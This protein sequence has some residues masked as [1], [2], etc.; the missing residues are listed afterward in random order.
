MQQI[1]I[2]PRIP[3]TTW[4]G[5]NGPCPPVPLPMLPALTILHQ[6]HKCSMCLPSATQTWFAGKFPLWLSR[7][8]ISPCSVRIEFLFPCFITKGKSM[9]VSYWLNHHVCWLNHHLS[10][11]YRPLNMMT[12]RISPRL[13]CRLIIPSSRHK[14][15]IQSSHIDGLKNDK[16]SPDVAH[17]YPMKFPY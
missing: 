13:F 4:R 14:V 9:F 3:K 2:P 12:F 17:H 7:L 10:S 11:I 16:K 1:V 6:F 5:Q 8:I 15:Y